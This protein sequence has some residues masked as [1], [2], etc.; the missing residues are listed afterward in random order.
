MR[1][2]G[3]IYNRLPEWARSARFRLALLYSSALFLLAAV[4]VATLYFALLAS[5]RGEPLSKRYVLPQPGAA[6]IED[7][8]GPLIITSIR[9]FET[10][11]NKHTLKNLKD[12]SFAALGALFVASLGVGWVI[13]GRVLAPIDR[14]TSVASEIEAMDLSRR[15]RLEGP[16]DELKRLADTFDRMLERLDD[17]FSIQRRFVADASHELRNPLA[18][19]RANLDVALSDPGATV[20]ELTQAAEVARRAV[21]RM[22]RL[23]DD[24]LA[25]ARLESPHLAWERFDLSGVV[26]EVLQEEAPRARERAIALVGRS[27]GAAPVSADRDA[28]KR[29]LSNLLDNAL[30]YSPGGT[31]VTIASGMSEGWAWLAVED[32][33][34]GVP[35][36]HQERIFE[37]FHRIDKSRSRAMGGSGLGLAIVRQIAEAHGGRAGVSSEPGAGATFFLYLP[38]AGEAG[39]PGRPPE[40]PPSNGP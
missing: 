37:R 17:A 32:Q 33:G 19:I 4:L 9:E 36:E 12:F 6:V 40:G 35:R 16:D 15:I 5:L 39:E 14:I 27:R 22:T 11:V 34:P 7:N 20:E 3:G 38:A 29:A 2:L 21:E 28:V 31:T 1:S 26:D 8:E 13:S 10:L 23:V 18:V 25:L 30:R 24:L